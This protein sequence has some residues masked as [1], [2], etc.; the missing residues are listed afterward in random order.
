MKIRAIDAEI[1]K[2][3]WGDSSNGGISSK[4]NNVYVVCDNGN[5]EFDTDEE[6]PENLCVIVKRELFGKNA[7]YIRPYKD[8]PKGSV[9][10]MY[11]GCIVC[12][13]DSRF[14]SHPLKLHDRTETAKEYEMYSR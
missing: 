1:F 2:P 12:T 13:S 5:H 14:N 9:G 11:G 4:Y 6:L 8:V 7:D 10:Y 3:K